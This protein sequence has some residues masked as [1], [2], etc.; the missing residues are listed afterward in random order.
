MIV[1]R[2]VQSG[3][4]QG[5]AQGDGAGGGVAV[6]PHGHQMGQGQIG[7][8]CVAEPGA[9]QILGRLAAQGGGLLHP[10]DA[11][12]GL[13]RAG[14]GGV[15]GFA[16]AGTDLHGGLGAQ[17]SGPAMRGA[18]GGRGGDGGEAG[19]KAQ[20]GDDGH[21]P[22]LAGCGGR[23]QAGPAAGEAEIG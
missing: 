21:Q 18:V 17:L 23:Q 10:I 6:Q 11:G 22:R 3:L 14:G 8:D 16:D 15:A 12:Q 7:Q 2:G 20:D 1:H 9:Q 4:G 13:G 5:A 19:Q